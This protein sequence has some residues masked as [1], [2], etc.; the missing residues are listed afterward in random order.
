MSSYNQ[1]MTEL[2]AFVNT[3][4]W[5]QTEDVN[6]EIQETRTRMK[7]LEARPTKL[8][9]YNEERLL[10]LKQLTLLLE[11]KLALI[12]RMYVRDKGILLTSRPAKASPVR[13][14]N[15]SL[16]GDE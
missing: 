1:K 9:S 3:F 16:Q 15:R 5:A 8:P 11:T 12:A 13:R 14:R 7:E 2:E 10:L 4:D 6:R